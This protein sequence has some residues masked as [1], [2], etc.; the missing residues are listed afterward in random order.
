MLLSSENK[1]ISLWLAGI[2]IFALLI[3]T[4]YFF[5][6]KATPFFLPIDNSL[7]SQ[8]YIEWARDIIAGN[9]VGNGIF[10]G[11]PLYAYFLSILL[12][13]L[14]NSL[15]SVIFVQLIM[16]AFNCVLVS[17]I[18]K[19][20][21]SLKIAVIAGIIGSLYLPFLF[22]DA[23]ISSSVLITLLNSL[24]IYLLLRFEAN[25]SLKTLIFCG[26]T[27]GLASLARATTLMF[28]PL[29]IIWITFS[30]KE[31]ELKKRASFCAIL[32][33]SVFAVIFPVTL[34]NYLVTGEKILITSYGGINFYIGNNPSADGLF[35]PP[36]G[37]RPDSKGLLEDSKKIAQDILKKELTMTQVSDFWIDNTKRLIAKNP[38]HFLNV[39]IKKFYYFYNSYEIPDI[40]NYY[41]IK[42]FVPILRL[43]V[44]TFIVIGPLGLLGLFLSLSRKRKKTIIYLFLVSYTAAIMLFFINARYRLT[45]VPIMII[46]SAFAL[47]KMLA[48]FNKK[49]YKLLGKQLLLLLVFII[50]TNLPMAR[51]GYAV[52]YNNLGI[53]LMNEGKLSEAEEAFFSSIDIDPVYA[54]AYNNLGT[55]YYNQDKKEKSEI[56][57]KKALDLNPDNPNIVRN[58]SSVIGIEQKPK[59]SEYTI[60]SYAKQ[61]EFREKELEYK[62][63]LKNDPLNTTACVNL[64]NIYLAQKNTDEALKYYNLALSIDPNL[65]LAHYNKGLLHFTIK[66][67]DRAEEEWE[68]VLALDADFEPA[69]EG[70]KRLSYYK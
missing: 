8:L 21:F 60:N 50:F 46:F 19:R 38:S 20:L 64:A 36:K 67:L 14:K 22:N 53:A 3:R 69:K 62:E 51:M 54:S 63:I 33:I 65:K 9:W 6:L 29:V 56:F 11:M 34:R 31:F 70:L 4:V 27:L 68:K 26:I 18:A 43:P 10:L 58:A 28:M 59:N 16:S 45:I 35:C 25:R 2:F 7:D 17:L 24:V 30:F 61:N 15:S 41:F 52:S 1:K 66:E 48:S 42:R 32:L 49:D 12:V 55:L 44:F 39:L 47:D 23:L 57:F 37:M 40:L 13:I 5:Q